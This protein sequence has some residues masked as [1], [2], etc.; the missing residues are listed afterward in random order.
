MSNMEQ[1]RSF[2][3]QLVDDLLKDIHEDA[4]ANNGEITYQDAVA[5]EQSASAAYGQDALNVFDPL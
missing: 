2:P 1:N 3:D 5:C 4:L